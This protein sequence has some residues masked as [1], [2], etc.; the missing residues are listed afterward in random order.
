ML[1]YGIKETT[2][3]T[4]TSTLTLQAVSGYP[5]VADVFPTGMSIYY[6]II[7][8]A[9]KPVEEGIGKVGASNTLSRDRILVTYNGTTYDDLSPTPIDL[10]GTNT[11]ICTGTPQSFE[12]AWPNISTTKTYAGSAA[13]RLI[14]DSRINWASVSG[15]GMTLTADR[16]YLVP[17][18]VSVV[19]EATGVMLYI[20]TGVAGKSVRAGLYN[21]GHDG[22][23][24]V[25][26]GETGAVSCATSGVSVSAGFSGGNVKLVPGMYVIAFVSDGAPAIGTVAAYPSSV[27]GV[28]A[29]Q[30]LLRPIS[31]VN[32]SHTFGALPASPANAATA[33]SSATSSNYPALGLT[34]V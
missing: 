8:N 26:L 1:G 3:T 7:D 32:L 22:S 21:I 2:T 4:G 17:F 28:Q 27:Y 10:V 30:S 14:V 6:S 12:L 16:L 20:G 24:G 5:R 31:Y 15:T 33:Y 25:L 29:N 18:Q 11:V 19:C 9:G 34:I 13:Q 23:E